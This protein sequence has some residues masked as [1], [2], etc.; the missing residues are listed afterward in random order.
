MFSI[1]I[2]LF[3]QKKRTSR[4]KYDTNPFPLL[5]IRRLYCPHLFVLNNKCPGAPWGLLAPAALLPPHILPKKASAPL[6]ET[7]ETD[8][9]SPSLSFRVRSFSQ[10]STSPAINSGRH[11]LPAPFL[12]PVKKTGHPSRTQR[13]TVRTFT[14][15]KS[16]VSCLVKYRFSS[17]S[18]FIFSLTFWFFAN[19]RRHVSMSAPHSFPLS[20]PPFPISGIPR[21]RNP[22]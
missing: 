21:N 17:I 19:N 3:Q 13:D 8:T 9:E 20:Y 10:A 15:N 12:L 2:I 11:P 18:G 16:A 1:T 4:K 7:A 6:P 22:P 14:R 5:T